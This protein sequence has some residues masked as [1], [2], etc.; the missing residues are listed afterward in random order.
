M[1]AAR[2]GLALARTAHMKPSSWRRYSTAQ[3]AFFEFV[4]EVY[5]GRPAPPSPPY[6]TVEV[7]EWVGDM[8]ARGVKSAATAVAGLN[9]AHVGGGG[10]PLRDTPA[11]QQAL[12]GWARTKPP[13]VPKKPFTGDMLLKVRDQ[14]DMQSLVGA[15]NLAMLVVARAG[16]F[17]G[18]SELCVAQLPLRRVTGGAEVDVHTKTDKHVDSTSVRRVPATGPGG[19]SPLRTLEHYLALSG[20]TDGFV[21]RNVSG[22]GARARSNARGVSRNTFTDVVKFW[23]GKLGFDA[24]EFASHSTKHGCAADVK[25]ANVPTDVAMSVTGHASRRS[26]NGYGGAEARRRAEAA[27]RRE[28]REA[29]AESAAAREALE[30]QVWTAAC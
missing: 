9:K 1:A 18:G 16:A 13:P 2:A 8:V 17:R 12:E 5:P 15:R 25:N 4:V 29:R 24:S 14:T 28:Q 3:R 11:I 22:G 26:Y 7:A 6:N 10:T 30:R 27:Q 21:F 23:A 20:H 19:L